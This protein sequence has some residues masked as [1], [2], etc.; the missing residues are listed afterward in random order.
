M[1]RS[2]WIEIHC[3]NPVVS[4]LETLT[5]LLDFGWSLDDHGQITILPLGDKE[6]FNWT[7]LSLS[8]KDKAFEIIRLKEIA[9]E[10]IGL[11]LTWAGSDVG[12]NVLLDKGEK[13]T[14]SLLINRKSLESCEFTDVSW[15]LGKIIPP[16]LSRKM[17]VTQIS[18]TEHV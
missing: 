4:S 11:T 8:E 18:W 7:R 14:F 13:I 5:A 12:V 6:E 1:S 3:W 17:S 15:Y 9:G 2:S 16:L 10:I